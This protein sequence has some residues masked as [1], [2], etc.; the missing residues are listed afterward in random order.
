VSLI[1][2]NPPAY[3]AAGKNGLAASYAVDFF[4]A[5]QQVIPLSGSLQGAAVFAKTLYINNFSNSFSVTV[6]NGNYELVVPA[7]ASAYVDIRGFNDVTLTI[8]NGGSPTVPVKVLNF[9]TQYGIQLKQ[10][11][12]A[13]TDPLISKVF[14]LYHFEGNDG[15]T[16]VA[17]DTL[18]GRV[19]NFAATGPY[20]SSADAATGVSSLYKPQAISGP[21]FSSAPDYVLTVNTVTIEFTLKVLQ[22][23]GFGGLV[24]AY[25]VTSGSYYGL[26][27]I[28]SGAG[29]KLSFYSNGNHQF[30]NATV[31]KFN[32]RY[33]IAY[34]QFGPAGA[35]AGTIY[36][37]GVADGSMANMPTMVVGNTISTRLFI[38]YISVTNT[39]TECFIDELRLTDGGRYTKN[40]T[41]VSPFPDR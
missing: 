10:S 23:S 39:T 5:S 40:Y 34:S 35:S 27:I 15:T 14:A 28:N 6:T 19:L 29:Y 8:E 38:D 7:Y 3:Q 26:A 12:T 30:D 11:S 33:R 24:H 2:L 37:N 36:V 4:Q 41:P 17:D 31:L 22:N 20:L 18:S 25:N 1:V 9:V 16:L 32:T 21:T 13:I